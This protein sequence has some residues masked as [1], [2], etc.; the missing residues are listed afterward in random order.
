MK[1]AHIGL[2]AYY[3]EGMTYQDNQ[4]A[5]ALKAVLRKMK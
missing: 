1:I 2:A 4:L 3:T 5:E